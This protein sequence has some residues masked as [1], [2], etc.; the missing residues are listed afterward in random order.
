MEKYNNNDLYIDDDCVIKDENYFMIKSLILCELC[1]KI[2]KSPMMCSSCQKNFCKDCIEKWED[3]YAHCP[4][5]CNNPT[6][7]KNN[8]KL[9]ILS[10]LKFIC[11]NCKEEVKYN[12]I[13][14]HVNSNCNR[15]EN[16]SKLSDILYKKKRLKQLTKEE[17]YYI[18]QRKGKITYITSK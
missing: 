3:N 11:K 10:L 9:A 12:D 15:N 17:M 2:L 1:N 8:D 5:K 14:T 6:Y 18:K 16:Q 7:I 13:Q 4:N